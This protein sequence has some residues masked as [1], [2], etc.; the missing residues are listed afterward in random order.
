MSGS[1]KPDMGSLCP[2]TS[3]AQQTQNLRSASQD[4]GIRGTFPITP[5]FEGTTKSLTGDGKDSYWSHKGPCV[6]AC[7]YCFEDSPRSD[8]TFACIFRRDAVE[9]SSQ[10][11]VALQTSPVYLSTA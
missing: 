5:T 9:S 1:V 7:R 10:P 11:L 4:A 2:Y 3:P 6:F 8:R